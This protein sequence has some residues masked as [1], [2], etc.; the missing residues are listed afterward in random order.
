MA[1][2][3]SA[4]VDVCILTADVLGISF[5]RTISIIVPCISTAV[6]TT[7]GTIIAPCIGNP[8]VVSEAAFDSTSSCFAGNATQKTVVG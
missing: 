5:H 1:I 4:L 3:S 7:D 6:R 2:L 8:D